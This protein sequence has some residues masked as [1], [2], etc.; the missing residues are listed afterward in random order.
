M[1]FTPK[2]LS[3]RFPRIAPEQ[4]PSAKPDMTDTINDIRNWMG[5]VI[6]GIPAE[7]R[8]YEQSNSAEKAIHAFKKSFSDEFRNMDKNDWHILLPEL[9]D[10]H[11]VCRENNVR[12]DMTG[13]DALPRAGFVTETSISR[14]PYAVEISVI[15]GESYQ[16]LCNPYSQEQVDRRL[17]SLSANP[18]SVRLRRE[19]PRI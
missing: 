2:W 15:F 1:R 18:V 5:M 16:F 9:H 3:D 19:H 6:D 17:K 11:E 13:F 4:T 14:Q 7:C 8:K 12:L 10:L